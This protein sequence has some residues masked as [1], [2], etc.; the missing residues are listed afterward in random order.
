MADVRTLLRAK[1]QEVR[2]SHRY[3]SYNP[4]GQLRCTACGIAIKHGSAWEGHLGSKAHRTSVARLREEE[5]K[6][7]D[8][9]RPERSLKRETPDIE[10]AIDLSS[11]KRKVEQQNPALPA[12]F[13]SK[14][15]DS[16]PS[17]HEIAVTTAMDLES[18]YERFQHE[19]VAPPDPL[20]TYDYATIVAEPQLVS[21]DSSGFPGEPTTATPA[22]A[23]E[24][25][26]EQR[27]DEEERELILDRLVEEERAQE[28]ADMRV[29]L[30]R[31]RL[32]AVK[33]K[34][35]VLTHRSMSTK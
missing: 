12:D 27:K 21:E 6:T 4:S 16:S 7:E 22:S 8:I 33:R 14:P 13:F 9:N 24:K 20:E 5:R 23:V 17:D 10:D 28:D 32:E 15:R 1:R 2:I 18:E 19:V 11:K 26:A 29:D 35:Q 34:R 3:A 31:K 25:E 30:M